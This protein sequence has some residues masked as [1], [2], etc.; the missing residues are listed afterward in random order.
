MTW[1]GNA[2]IT[3][4]HTKREKGEG[5]G[6][7]RRSATLRTATNRSPLP[8]PPPGRRDVVSGVHAPRPDAA[9]APPRARTVRRHLAH[10][11]PPRPGLLRREAAGV[12][13]RSRE[14]AL[15]MQARRPRTRLHGWAWRRHQ[16]LARC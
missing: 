12:A 9:S 15:G 16:T 14:L 8:S 4:S 11:G 3:L 6:T 13:V 2:D 5:R 10:R 7:W 1:W